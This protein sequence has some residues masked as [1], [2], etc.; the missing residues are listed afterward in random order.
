M[1]KNELLGNLWSLWGIQDS[2]LQSYRSIFITS[3]SILLSLAVAVLSVGNAYF[4][5]ILAGP[6]IFL[7]VLWLK[8]CSARARD[9]T[10]TQR[11]IEKVEK[12]EIE[13]FDVLSEFK[14]YQSQYNT[15]RGYIYKDWELN[16]DEY[17]REMLRSPT[18][19]K[20]DKYLPNIYLFLW[21]IVIGL[22]FLQMLT[23]ITNKGLVPS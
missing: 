3:E 23:Y 4:S 5:L 2:L 21:V 22:V 9:V 7:H 6:G 12:D 16:K 15:Q 8:I 17:F 1:N 18:R 19:V 20:M 13:R 10:F 11:V 14:R